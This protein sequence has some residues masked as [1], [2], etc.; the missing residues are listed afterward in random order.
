MDFIKLERVEPLQSSSSIV[1]MPRPA[2]NQPVPFSAANYQGGITGLNSQFNKLRTKTFEPLP[3]PPEV[4]P[5]MAFSDE[6]NEY[7]NLFLQ[8]SERVDNLS[9][10]DLL[11]PF[12]TFKPPLTKAS[13]FGKIMF[14]TKL[15]TRINKNPM[16]FDPAI[17]CCDRQSEKNLYDCFSL[18]NFNLKPLSELFP[19]SGVFGIIVK[20]RKKIKEPK[21]YKPITKGEVDAIFIYDSACKANVDKEMA[22]LKGIGG[23]G[24]PLLFYIACMDTIEMRIHTFNRCAPVS[25]NWDTKVNSLT[26]ELQQ[27]L[28]L[29]P[30]RRPHQIAV[31]AWNDHLSQTIFNRLYVKDESI[32]VFKF[33]TKGALLLELN[34]FLL[35]H[36]HP[37]EDSVSE[38]V[39]TPPRNTNASVDEA[40]AD[41]PSVAATSYHARGSASI[42][43]TALKPNTYPKQNHQASASA[44]KSS[45]IHPDRARM[46]QKIDT[47]DEALNAASKKRQR[48]EDFDVEDDKH[49]KTKKTSEVSAYLPASLG[50]SPTT[51]SPGN[52][53][54]EEVN[55][56][57]GVKSLAN[58]F[59]TRF[60][61]FFANA[62]QKFE[63]DI[64]DIKL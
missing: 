60:N 22:L 54:T 50:R 47:S 42:T 8:E 23:K 27:S 61:S 5:I 43:T 39:F 15:L 24:T 51:T 40:A 34:S 7:E 13:H 41:R 36:P 26:H 57:T 25:V 58:D 1:P 59:T 31:N 20:I 45:C 56:S 44:D 9:I 11:S 46:I 18:A 12:S 63:N 19:R 29:Q 37:D 53:G 49:H 21:E 62:F 48:E 2:T 28:L 3:I 30:N 14:L 6:V 4:I 32:Y 55:E 38:A 33:P 52:V 64:R 16:N 10:K 17:I 35:H